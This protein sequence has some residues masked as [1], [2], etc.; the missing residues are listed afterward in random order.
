MCANQREPVKQFFWHHLRQDFCGLKHEVC[1]HVIHAWMKRQWSL[2]FF[3]VFLQ[4]IRNYVSSLIISLS[5]MWNVLRTATSQTEF[6][7]SI[8]KRDA[9]SIL[10]LAV[11]EFSFVAKLKACQIMSS[12][13]THMGTKVSF[14]IEWVLCNR[15]QYIYNFFFFLIHVEV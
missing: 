1:Q 8:K 4:L 2:F 12:N 3:F 14:V 11:A 9:F 10:L 15:I 13:D 7:Q 6:Q 5:M